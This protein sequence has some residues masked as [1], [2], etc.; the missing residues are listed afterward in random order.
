VNTTLWVLQIVVAALFLVHAL[1]H[2]YPP[3]V[4]RG[5]MDEQNIPRMRAVSSVAELLASVGLILPALVGIAT[6]LTPLAAL[7]LV[8][9]MLGATAFHL[10]RNE[11]YPIPITLVLAALSGFIAYGRTFLE[12]LG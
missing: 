9:I 3:R 5:S 1:I 4:L 6:W 2:I 10:S 11:I 7:G 8:F 12:P